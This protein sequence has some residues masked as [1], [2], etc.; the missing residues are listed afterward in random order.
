[1]PARLPLT[2]EERR[3]RKRVQDHNAHIRRM[4]Y[5]G[6]NHRGTMIPIPNGAEL[7]HRDLQTEAK[8][9]QPCA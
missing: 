7:R 4:E 1:M 3:E 2:D 9:T 5:W 6:L 8:E